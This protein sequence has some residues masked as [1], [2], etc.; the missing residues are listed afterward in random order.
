[1]KSSSR[2]TTLLF[3]FFCHELNTEIND[4]FQVD[5]Q[6]ACVL[7]HAVE[8][9]RIQESNATKL[10]ST[11]IKKTSDSSVD[12]KLFYISNMHDIILVFPGVQI[13]LI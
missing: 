13:L 2:R 11:Y 7:V 1:M 10:F 8:S 9:R 3:Y 5:S 12:R 6:F 4:D